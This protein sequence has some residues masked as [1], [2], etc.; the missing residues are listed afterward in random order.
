VTKALGR[1]ELVRQGWVTALRT[2]PDQQN[3]GGWR[4]RA[5]C[6]RPLRCALQVLYDIL[7]MGYGGDADGASSGVVAQEIGTTD[8]TLSVVMFLND[9]KRMTFPQIADELERKEFILKQEEYV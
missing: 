9:E 5:P 7:G 8:Q 3:I 1:M 2:N 6:G 4:G